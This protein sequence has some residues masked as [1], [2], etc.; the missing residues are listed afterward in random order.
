MAAGFSSFPFLVVSFRVKLEN[1][2]LCGACLIWT[3]D[4]IFVEPGLALV[5]AHP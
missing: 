1:K 5:H 2:R 4:L 3:S